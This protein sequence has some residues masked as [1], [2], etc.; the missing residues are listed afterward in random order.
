M[1]K[2]KGA[3][4]DRHRDRLS[5]LSRQGKGKVNSGNSGAERRAIARELPAIKAI[6]ES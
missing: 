6:A 2:G 3:K 1:P 4:G 5:T